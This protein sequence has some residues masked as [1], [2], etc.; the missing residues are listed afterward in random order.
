M[1]KKD[2]WMGSVSVAVAL[3]IVSAIIHVALGS[4]AAGP[5]VNV[6]GGAIQGLVDDRFHSFVFRGIPFAAPPVGKLRFMPP[7][8]VRSWVG[9]RPAFNFSDGC[10][11]MCMLPLPVATC[12]KH[13]SEDCLYLNVFTPTPQRVRQAVRLCVDLR[14]RL[15]G[16]DR[17]ACPL[18]ESA[19]FAARQGVVVVTFNHR[20]M[21]FG[22]Y[23][24]GKTARGKQSLQD[25]RK[26]LQWIQ[27]NIATFGGSPTRVTLAG[28]SSGAASVACHLTSPL[29]RGLFQAAVIASNPWGVV[30]QEPLYA[31]PL[32]RTFATLAGCPANSSETLECLQQADAQTINLAGIL[33]HN[34]PVGTVFTLMMEWLPVVDGTPDLPKQPMDAVADGTFSIMP[35]MLG[36]LADDGYFAVALV[37]FALDNFAASLAITA[38][39][40]YEHAVEI[41]NLYGDPGN[42]SDARGFLGVIGTDY[43]FKCPTRYFARALAKVLTPLG[44]PIWKYEFSHV[45]SFSRL[46]WE[47]RTLCFDKVCH[48]D[49]VPFIFSN[50]WAIPVP[51][52]ITAEEVE[53][54]S[55]YQDMYGAFI[56]SVGRSVTPRTPHGQPTWPMYD[57]RF[58][59]T[60]NVSV[61]PSAPLVLPRGKYCD[62]YDSIGYHRR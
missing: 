44:I 22:G 41:K 18:Y 59:S 34:V 15:H 28:V 9:V 2:R 47:K 39:F 38:L 27:D 16:G 19:E 7:A 56:R 23:Y 35:V 25:Q 32:A 60:M 45:P 12:S 55:Y 57:A 36:A 48:S 17:Q 46:I 37:P 4:V 53:L 10:M 54:M 5:V 29:S 6:T 58:D 3:L 1:E 61:P 51:I 13:E 62:Y 31:L 8:D 42:V 14:G 30:L 24:D 21:V 43:M 11:G 20:Q 33:A 52:N 40:G 26:A 49:D 50:P